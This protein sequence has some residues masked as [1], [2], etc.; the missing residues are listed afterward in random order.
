MEKI[1]KLAK[2]HYKEI[3]ELT[4]QYRSDFLASYLDKNYNRGLEKNIVKEYDKLF[5]QMACRHLV[6]Y[7]MVRDSI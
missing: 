6:E 5:N 7:K 1:N 4:N 2:R 3:E